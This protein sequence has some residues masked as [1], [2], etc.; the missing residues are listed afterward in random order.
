MTYVMKLRF[1]IF[2]FLFITL[3]CGYGY[4]STAQIPPESPVLKFVSVFSNSGDVRIEWDNISYPSD[5]VIFVNDPNDPT[6][7][8]PPKWL[9]LDTVTNNDNYQHIGANAHQ[10]VRLYKIWSK[11]GEN[12]SSDSYW[13]PTTFLQNTFDTCANTVNLIWTNYVDELYGEG[14]VNFTFEVYRNKDS[15]GFMKISETTPITLKEF[16]DTDIVDGAQYEYYITAIPSHDPTQESL[17][18]LI[19]INSDIN[20]SPSFITPLSASANGNNTDVKFRIAPNS[21]L[22]KYLLLES[23][24]STGNFDTVETI[25]SSDYE[26]VVT[27]TNSE[28]ESILKFYKLAAI[29]NCN[30][31]STISDTIINNIVLEISYENNIASLSWNKFNETHLISA[32]YDLYKSIDNGSPVL[33]RS[34]SNFYSYDDDLSQENMGGQFC[35]FIQASNQNSS[36][37]NN[38][39]SNLVCAFL[40]PPIYIPEAFTPNGDNRNDVFL[41]KFSFVPNS[42]E[43]KIYNRWGNVVYNTNN[44]QEGWNGNERNG[45]TASTGTYVYY[46]YIK[47]PNNETFEKRGNITVIHP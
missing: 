14:D 32:N 9:T 10:G 26:F 28:P 35:Y 13:F 45:K 6:L 21:E 47:L 41:P 1:I 18:N 44:Y 30:Q 8:G 24:S 46:L 27:H 3:L 15:E 43:L 42:Y 5:V 20:Q 36:I 4:N 7:S 16:I 12:T 17:S 33:I 38:S 39:K 37:D 2:G 31:V 22:N 11:I 23:S 40:E 19:V 34:F 29:N 25:I